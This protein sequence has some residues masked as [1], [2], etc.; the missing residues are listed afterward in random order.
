MFKDYKFNLKEFIGSLGDLGVLI[1][2]SVALILL[3]GVNPTSL[4][5]VVGLLY[6]ITGIYFKIPFPVQPMK[7]MAVIA[8]VT[9]AKPEV[10]SAAGIIMGIILILLS[11]TKLINF[12]HKLFTL[13]IVRGIQFG[14]GI[15]LIIN[16]IKLIIGNHQSHNIFPLSFGFVIPNFGFPDIQSFVLAFSTLVLPQLPVTIGNSVI[17]TVDTAQKYFNEKSSKVTSVAIT[18]SL[19][20][21]NII[22]GVLGGMP[23]CHGAG[24][25]TAHYKFGARTG[26][27]NIM[28][29]SI[30]II[31]AI[32]LGKSI[33]NI[34]S[35]I[36][37]SILGSLLIYTGIKHAQ[38]IQ[39]LFGQKEKLFF[40]T[41]VG[42]LCVV[43]DMS[44]A[45]GVGLS[46]SF[47]L[48]KL[49]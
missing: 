33:A 20:I 3:N 45:I 24:G 2:L 16:G 37:F 10:L 36:P 39:D 47:L 27:A 22:S 19:G 9:N 43:S 14:L 38:L 35:L 32:F 40:A 12:I 26:G 5:F 41:A 1:P 11:V 46:C 17:A 23:V 6:F 29:G 49:I 48:K 31:A 25:L 28:L 21:A 34:F 44:V 13:P 4:F 30:F 18:T 42:L 8:I 7:A 15:M